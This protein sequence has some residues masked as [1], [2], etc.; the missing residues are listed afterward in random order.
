MLATVVALSA[1]GSRPARTGGAAPTTSSRP[2]SAQWDPGA[3]SQLRTLAVRVARALPGQCTEPGLLPRPAYA[4]AMQRLRL[5]VPLA[6][7]DCTVNGDVA[8]LSVFP[9]ATVRANWV[10]V[11]TGTLCRRA[12][13]AH[14]DLPGLHWAVGGTWAMQLGSEWSA[15][16]VAAGLHG[17]YQGA[18]CAGAV[19]IDWETPAEATAQ[20]IA[21]EIAARRT[22]GCRGFML[23][24]RSEYAR[25]P[26]YAHRLPAAYAQCTGPASS[27]VWIAAFSSR[28]VSRDRFVTTEATM[29]CTTSGTVQAVVGRDWA[30]I[31]THPK[32]AAVVAVATGGTLRDPACG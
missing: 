3:T 4:Q 24:D 6:V 13:A 18:A 1:C 22:D 26:Q 11:R 29:L 16:Q 31:A 10:T 27:T 14:A 20:R 8:E 32:V 5:Q 15:R 2:V 25:N 30:V 21:H 28:T 17:G 23:L 7:A 12:K 19:P 9:S